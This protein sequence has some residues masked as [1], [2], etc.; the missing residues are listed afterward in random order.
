MIPE[1]RTFSN[2]IV[3]PIISL[4][5]YYRDSQFPE[6]DELILNSGGPV[7][8][9]S[10]YSFLPCLQSV[11]ILFFEP[12]G[13]IELKQSSALQGDIILRINNV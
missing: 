7:T 1:F 3:N 4:L 9:L 6:Q 11:R 10:E 5:E 2:Y 13:E 8:D 12:L